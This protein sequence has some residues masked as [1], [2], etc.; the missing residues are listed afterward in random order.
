MPE[1]EDKLIH[2]DF[3]KK[4]A[5]SESPDHAKEV[6]GSEPVEVKPETEK[7]DS[8]TAGVKKIS[9][10]GRFFANAWACTKFCNQG[11]TSTINKENDY[12][13]NV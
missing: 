10:D 11:N 2:F 3:R 8:F 5:E 6:V 4:T 7:L 12:P 13:R 1:G 9:R